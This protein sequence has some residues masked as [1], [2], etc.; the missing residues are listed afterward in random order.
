M[1]GCGAETSAGGSA[2]SDSVRSSG[3]KYNMTERLLPCSDYGECFRRH[4]NLR[5]QQDSHTRIAKLQDCTECDR[6]FSC[7]KH[8]IQH[9]YVHARDPFL[10]CKVCGQRLHD[11]GQLRSHHKL[12][13]E[14][15]MYGYSCCEQKFGPAGDLHMH[16]EGSHLGQDKLGYNACKKTYHKI[17]VLWKYQ[18][19]H[20]KQ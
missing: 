1:D 8:L 19:T 13:S 2:G 11:P 18:L 3:R 5:S 7:L 10:T 16:R 14:W 12:H 17:Q 9:Q 20:S 6:D 4:H 15:A